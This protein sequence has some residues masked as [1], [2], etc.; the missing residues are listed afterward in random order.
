MSIINTGQTNAETS[1]I[2]ADN[3]QNPKEIG[4]IN[5]EQEENTQY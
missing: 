2:D 1:I 4:E 3:Y 5:I